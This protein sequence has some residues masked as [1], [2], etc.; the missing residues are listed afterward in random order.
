MPEPGTLA[1]LSAAGL[2]LLTLRALMAAGGIESR[3]IT[4][5]DKGRPR[6]R[7]FSCAAASL[8][9]VGRLLQPLRGVRYRIWYIR[10]Q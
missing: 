6:R 1:L 9:A 7:P 4:R 3:A 10:L 8:R 2:G 5:R